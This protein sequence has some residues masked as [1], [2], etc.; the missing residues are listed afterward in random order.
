MK[1]KATRCYLTHRWLF[2]EKEKITS[3]GAE[4]RRTA[5]LGGKVVRSLW[6]MMQFP[7]KNENRTPM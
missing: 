3:I 4:V 7:P 2:L 6:K 5:P 1:I